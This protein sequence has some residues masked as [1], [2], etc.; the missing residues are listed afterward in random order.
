MQSQVYLRVYLF[1]RA[2]PAEVLGPLRLEGL[3]ADARGLARVARIS[4]V[5]AVGIARGWASKR[6]EE[7][8]QEEIH[9]GADHEQ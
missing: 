2:K 6:A 9:S 1:R 3:I 7:H 5:A 8:D 4:P